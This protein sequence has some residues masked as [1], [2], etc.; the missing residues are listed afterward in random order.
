M[1]EFYLFWGIL[2]CMLLTSSLV[3]AA[4]EGALVTY[5]PGFNGTFPSKQYSG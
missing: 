3:E 2:M 1:G 4:Q 5:L